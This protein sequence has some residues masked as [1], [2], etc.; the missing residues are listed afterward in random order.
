MT[1]P[2]PRPSRR[3]QG[4]SLL[5][6]VAVITIMGVLVSSATVFMR[7]PVEA[8]FGTI[9]RAQ[10]AGDADNA[11]R[12]I[13]REVKRA[14]PNS[15]RTTSSVSNQCFEY[16]PLSGGGRYRAAKSST[17]TGDILDFST[18]DTSFDVLDVQAAGVSLPLFSSGTFYAVVYNLST[19][20]ISVANPHPGN[21]YEG[22]NRAL[23]DSS[24]SSNSKITLVAPGKQF[25]YESPGRRFHVLPNYS[26]V[27][28]CS[29]G[30]LLRSTRSIQATALSSCPATGTV[31]VGNVDCAS[32][33]FNYTSLTALRDGLLSMVL[34]LTQSDDSI[35][36]F[37]QVRVDNVP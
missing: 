17:N 30:N 19:S 3:Q 33:S 4:F 22:D 29:G 10:L 6:A 21:A 34:V 24:A 20:A 11:L 15:L 13:A 14:L 25:P 7:V 32:S 28:S 27:Y 18:Q 23:V 31:L 36:L 2:P 26:V 8:Y 9:R 5:E 12:R 35:R 1:E 37:E 16:L